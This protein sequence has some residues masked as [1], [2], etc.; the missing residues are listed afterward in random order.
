MLKLGESEPKIDSQNAKKW[1]LQPNHKNIYILSRAVHFLPTNFN[2][3]SV[4]CEPAYIEH[5]V[6]FTSHIIWIFS[7][8]INSMLNYMIYLNVYI[9]YKFV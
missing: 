6:E 9:E 5:T 2:F 4:V 7:A 1:T 8:R 3:Q